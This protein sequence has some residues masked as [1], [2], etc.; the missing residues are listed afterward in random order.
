MEET[1]HNLVGSTLTFR[2]FKYNIM[3]KDQP[4]I[5]RRRSHYTDR[6]IETG[7]PPS[8]ANEHESELRRRALSD[9]R[10]NKLNFRRYQSDN[11]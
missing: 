7:N 6:D 8:P 9:T 10:G 11:C 5:C 3:C 1:V 2:W 4:W